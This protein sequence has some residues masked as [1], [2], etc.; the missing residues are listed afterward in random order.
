MEPRKDE[1][2]LVVFI[3][4]QFLAVGLGADPADL[5]PC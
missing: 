3:A 2:V 4:P 1:E 5:I